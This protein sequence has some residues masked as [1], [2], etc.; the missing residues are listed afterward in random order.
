MHF[1]L[2]RGLGAVA[3]VLA[4]A[5]AASAQGSNDCATA[6]VIAGTG[7]FNVVTTGARRSN[8]SQTP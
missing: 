4:L 5:V 7:T 1:Q 2:T 3:S 8:T 6:T